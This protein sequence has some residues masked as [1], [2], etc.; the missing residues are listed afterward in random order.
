M[1]PHARP[2]PLHRLFK[3]QLPRRH[4]KILHQLMPCGSEVSPH[5]LPRPFFA[6]SEIAL[7]IAAPHHR[8]PRLANAR[9]DADRSETIRNGASAAALRHT[10][11]GIII[12]THFLERG[13]RRR[14]V[15]LAHISRG[16]CRKY[17][18]LSKLRPS[19]GSGC[20]T[21]PASTAK[22]D[23]AGIRNTFLS[24]RLSLHYTARQCTTRK[25]LGGA[26]DA[27]NPCPRYG[28]LFAK[29]TVR[30]LRRA[31]FPPT[32]GNLPH[33]MEFI[34]VAAPG[35]PASNRM[36]AWRSNTS[37]RYSNRVSRFGGRGPTLGV[38][39]FARAKRVEKYFA[40]DELPDNASG[41][42]IRAPFLRR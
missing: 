27:G 32:A 41:A 4:G 15:N 8:H 37:R 16:W 1:Q 28:F 35:P 30:F 3:C 42:P 21:I 10:S 25:K 33:P 36:N 38:E 24:R 23:A 12:E 7:Q 14:S 29:P 11:H 6:A 17:D 26:R 20:T 34:V 40:T 2:R 18:A 13:P 22:I 31:Q 9:R 5:S 39:R 19:H